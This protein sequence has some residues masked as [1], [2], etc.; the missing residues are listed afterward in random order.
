MDI[1]RYRD[2]LESIIPGVVDTYESLKA[3]N[4]M[5]IYTSNGEFYNHTFF[6]R[7]TAMAAKFVTDFE[8]QVT[9]DTILALA[10]VQG[11]TTNQK[12]HEQPGRIH[13]EFRDFKTWK[14]T[15]VERTLLRFFGSKWGSS[16]GQLLTY[17][18]T[19]T[20]AL[21]IRLV[22]KY[23]TRV[24]KS[25]L[26][27]PVKNQHGVSMPL[28]E[29]VVLAADWLM[30]QLN[31][32]DHFVVQPTNRWALPY[33][34]FQDSST[35][36]PRPDGRLANYRRGMTFTEVQA[37]V[38]DALEDTTAL[39]ESH[40]KRHEW[41]SAS[42]AMRRALLSDFWDDTE[43]FFGCAYDENGLVSMPNVSAG[44]TLNTSLWSE[45]PEPQRIERISSI[46]KRLFSDDFLTPVGLRTRSLHAEQPLLGVVE[47]HGRLTVWPMFTFMV[48]EGLRRHRLHRLA[49]ELE[50]RLVNGIN[51]SGSF[52]EFIVIDAGNHILR[53]VP[54]AKAEVAVDAQMLPEKN[55][56]FTVIPA[57]VLAWRAT[58][59]GRAWPAQAA[60]Q[61]ELEDA[62]LSS[63]ETTDRLDPA[64]AATEV[65]TIVPTKFRR[66]RGNLRST[67]Y[68][69]KQRSKM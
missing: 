34:T 2:E 64:A 16:D 51:M 69:L 19:D 21:Y 9:R 47:Y 54:G 41:Q 63:I 22:H 13:H 50:H 48:I 18:A 31:E 20:T 42:H 36:Y 1:S 15:F 35:A 62:I 45:V 7:D 61:T 30:S 68:F 43:Q 66:G 44:W 56:A 4:G 33:Q 25:F 23:V 28:S 17:Y 8:H 52:D 58:N 39:L 40:P 26:N 46:V 29:S 60:W 10:S 6:G 67:Y 32:H 27:Q 57:M 12:T 38:I 65:A 49:Q 11:V 14:G 59:R 37:F 3:T 55:I 24:D 5:G 53:S